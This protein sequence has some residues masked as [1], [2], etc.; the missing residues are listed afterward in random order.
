MNT[1][2]I[3]LAALLSALAAPAFADDDIAA[4]QSEQEVRRELHIERGPGPMHAPLMEVN[5]ADSDGFGMNIHSNPVKGAPYSAEVITERLQTLPDGNQITSRRS[6]MSYRDSAGRTRQEV[7]GADNELRT[8][9]INDDKGRLVLRPRDKTGTRIS[10][11]LGELSRMAAEHGRKAAEHAAER[12]RLAGERARE[13]VEALRKEGKLAENEGDRHREQVIVR[14]TERA[15]A[16]A[17][18]ATRRA[19]E[20]QVRVLKD[21]EARTEQMRRI[22]PMIAR[23]SGEMK[24]ARNATTRELGTREIEGV[25]AEGKLRS[26]EIPAGEVG[27]TRPIVVTDE[28]WYSPELQVTVYSRHSDPRSGDRI[29]RLDNIRRAEPAAELFTAPAGY[30]IRDPAARLKKRLEEKAMTREDKAKDKQ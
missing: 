16:A 5:H 26:Y 1:K 28:I 8:I 23:A 15:E 25:K 29:Y 30:E 24:Y 19:E 3:L 9:L 13:R 21:V 7:R 6:A 4:A 2:P 10:Q 18:A 22:A 12:S 20:I 17:Q 27:N 11:D 14:R